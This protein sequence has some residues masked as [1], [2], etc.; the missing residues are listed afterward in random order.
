MGS[1]AES[2]VPL[3]EALARKKPDPGIALL[4]DDNVE[5]AVVE[6]A[7]ED[8]V[9]QD[10][11]ITS[12]ALQALARISTNT[13]PFLIKYLKNRDSGIRVSAAVALG[14]MGP[15]AAA[16]VGSLEALLLDQE[17]VGRSYIEDRYLFNEPVSHAAREALDKI[18]GKSTDNSNEK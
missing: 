15:P 18:R 9:P 2:A 5:T 13:V 14:N 11:R 12:H 6:V 7:G 16:S 17:V 8:Q 3:I 1:A 4:P 10:P